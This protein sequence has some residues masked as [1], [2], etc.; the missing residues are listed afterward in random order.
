M[1]EPGLKKQALISALVE[2]ES[3]DVPEL[4]P[5]KARSIGKVDAQR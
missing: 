5:G 3:D 4:F 2:T 1:I